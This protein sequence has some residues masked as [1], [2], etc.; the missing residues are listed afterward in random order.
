MGG[1]LRIIY[2]FMFESKDI[3]ITDF[4]RTFVESIQAS[5][6]QKISGNKTNQNVLPGGQPIPTSVYTSPKQGS[7][8]DTNDLV[9]PP[10]VTD[11][12]TKLLQKDD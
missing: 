9:Q 1:L 2:A 3:L 10:S 6:I 7:W 8:M 5:T 4:D 11:N 12:T